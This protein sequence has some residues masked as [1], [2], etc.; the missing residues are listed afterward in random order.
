M[1]LF[2]HKNLYFSLSL[3]HCIQQSTIYLPTDT[4]SLLKLFTNLIQS[5]VWL[6]FHTQF[7]IIYNTIPISPALIVLRFCPALILFFFQTTSFSSFWFWHFS[8]A[9][10]V[11]NL[12]AVMD[13]RVWWCKSSYKKKKLHAPTQE[14]IRW[15][16]PFPENIYKWNGSLRRFRALIKER[17]NENREM[18][19]GSRRFHAIQAHYKRK[20]FYL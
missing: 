19:A 9:E 16:Q 20:W 7:G 17:A 10:R 11:P 4:L 13:T 3:I 2:C 6:H 12:V 1:G 15:S 5:H 14:P 18:T 8:S